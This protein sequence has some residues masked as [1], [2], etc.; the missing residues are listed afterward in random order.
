M[1]D[2]PTLCLMAGVDVAAARADLGC[3]LVACGVPGL[4]LPSADGLMALKPQRGSECQS[5]PCFDR[6]P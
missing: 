4:G 3:V 6:C 1:I 5:S 2:L